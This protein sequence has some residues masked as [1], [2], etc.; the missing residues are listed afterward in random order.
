MEG[1]TFACR[2]AFSAL[3]DTGANPE[4]IVM[5]GG[6][7]RS[8]FWRQMVADV[9][10]LPV[11][12]LATTDQAA[13]GAALLA[14]AGVTQLDPV[15]TAQR[16][17]RYGPVT[18]PNIGMHARYNELH[19][20]FREAYGPVVGVSHKLSDWYEASIGPRLVPRPIR[21]RG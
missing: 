11:Y 20:L 10:G 14:H 2:D 16:W 12:A 7:S 9:F 18:E 1:V 5:A 21:R 13:M 6:G 4:R 8:P 15:E 19:Q 17:A 3:Q